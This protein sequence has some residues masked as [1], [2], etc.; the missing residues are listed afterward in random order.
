HGGAGI[1]KTFSGKLIANALFAMGYDPANYNYINFAERDKRKKVYEKIEEGLRKCERAIFVLDEVDKVESNDFKVIIP[2]LNR[3]MDSMEVNPK[4][5][6]F[7]FISNAGTKAV[8]DSVIEHQDRRTISVPHLQKILIDAVLSE[9]GGH[10]DS[11]IVK[12]G[13]IDYYVPFMPLTKDHVKRC[14][15][16]EAENL[17]IDISVREIETLA[18]EVNYRQVGHEFYSIFGCGTIESRMKMFKMEKSYKVHDEV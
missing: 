8:N 11:E 10:M 15:R 1:G 9:K 5:A 14:I 17:K 18:D 16:Q 13:L 6:I 7:L 12:R 4:K 2:F 3:H